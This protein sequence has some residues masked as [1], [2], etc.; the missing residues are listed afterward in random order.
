MSLLNF[1]E[2]CELLAQK[3]FLTKNLYPNLDEGMT[4]KSDKPS[5]TSDSM[6][7]LKYLPLLFS[8]FP[9]E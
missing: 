3:Y 1:P 5:N 8:I 7:V 4:L 2:N 6:S 9:F